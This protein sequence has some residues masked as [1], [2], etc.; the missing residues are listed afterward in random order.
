[1]SDYSAVLGLEIHVQLATKSKMF[2]RCDNDAAGKA[3]NTTV[4]PVCLGLPGTLPVPNRTAVEWAI[5]TALALGCAIPAESKFDRKQ[6][7][8]PDLPKGYQISQYD[9]P[10]GG[11]GAFEFDLTAADGTRRSFTVGVTRLHLEEDAGK[12]THPAG[13]D[14]SLVD[15]NRAGTPLMEIVTDPIVVADPADVPGIAK[16]FLQELRL[17]MRYLEVSGADMEKG[18]LRCDA[19]I[20]LHQKDAAAWGAK[21]EVKN[22]NSFRFVERALKAEIARQAAALDAGETISQETRGYDETTQTTFSQR[23]KEEAMDYRYFAEPD[24][25]PLETA[26]LD[27][28]RLQSAI[29]E[30]PVAR[31]RRWRQTGVSEEVITVVTADRREAGAW[32]AATEKQPKTAAARGKLWLTWRGAP[33]FKERVDGGDFSQ[34]SAFVGDTASALASGRLPSSQV[35]KLAAVAASTGRTAAELIKTDPA[36]APADEGDLQKL[37][38]E[39]IAANPKAAADYRAGNLSAKQAIVGAVMKATGGSAN[40]TSLVGLIEETLA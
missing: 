4:C 36:F 15:L 37:V 32:E 33:E 34:L 25:P 28:D 18:H 21:V 24:L 2:C 30:L 13:K 40:P 3:P 38:D 7:F 16:T 27:L 39:A 14:Y 11:P 10:F 8:Y 5:K 31:R 9:Q 17:L 29:P 19:N 6:Y 23:S 26:R 20:S 1:M 22:M 35:K 12:L